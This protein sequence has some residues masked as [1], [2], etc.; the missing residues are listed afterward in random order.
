MSD[1]KEYVGGLLAEAKK[2]SRALAITST[3][4]KDDALK[5]MAERILDSGE[6]LSAANEKDLEA[7]EKAGLSA[8][9]LDRL[10]LTEKRVGEMAEGLL[11]VAA[12]RDPGCR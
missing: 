5:R 11:T 12:L 8:A 9:M 10:R 2:A 1:I 3:A 7:S 6:R 4:R